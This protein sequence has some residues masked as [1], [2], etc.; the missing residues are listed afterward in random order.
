MEETISIIVDGVNLKEK[1]KHETH[2]ICD[3]KITDR[4]NS[5]FEEIREWKNNNIA[6]RDSLP[7][8]H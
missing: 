8:Q 5:D 2:V 4:G 3:E 1:N 7:R 6:L